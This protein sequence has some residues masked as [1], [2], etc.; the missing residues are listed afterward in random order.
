[1][2]L[3]FI[4][5]V[6]ALLLGLTLLAVPASAQDNPR[7]RLQTTFGD[8][9]LEL[10]AERAPVSTANFLTYVRA[11][12]YDGTLFHRTIPG[13]VIQGGGFTPGLRAKT[14]RAPIVNEARNGLS[15]GIGTI[16]MARTNVI[17]SATSQF[18]IN[19]RNNVE[20]NYSND[21]AAGFGYAVFGR[22]VEG[23][24]VV[25]RIQR[26]ATHTVGPFEDVPVDDVLLLAAVELGACVGDCDEDGIV[27]VN[28][29][30]GMLG[31]TL[32]TASFDLCPAGDGNADG[33]ITV[34][35]ILVAVTAALEGCAD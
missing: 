9:V 6:V 17:N 4:R 16:A 33:S 24:D 12:F 27:T 30:L 1:M 19:T 3:V 20:L 34:D 28:E 11:G 26:V 2:T 21:S 22:V 7:V 13:F 18:F 10:D 31:I 32:G 8:V 35:E 29:I 25:D 15:N 14:T 5:P 23:L